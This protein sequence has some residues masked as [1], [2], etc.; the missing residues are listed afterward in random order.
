[1]LLITGCKVTH[2]CDSVFLFNSHLC[3]QK[4][5]IFGAHK[6]DFGQLVNLSQNQRQTHG[7]VKEQHCKAC[8]CAY[9]KKGWWTLG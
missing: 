3:R 6:F 1:M 5:N 7:K 8:K 9:Y 2:H 4:F